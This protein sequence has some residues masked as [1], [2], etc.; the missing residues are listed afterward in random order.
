M[1]RP[2]HVSGDG[3]GGREQGISSVSSDTCGFIPVQSGDVSWEV[4]RVEGVPSWVSGV[5][6]GVPER[7]SGGKRVDGGEWG[8]S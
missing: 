7:G 2:R 6:K 8:M 4:P 3:T 5:T 1:D